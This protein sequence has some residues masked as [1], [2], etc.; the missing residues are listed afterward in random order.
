MGDVSGAARVG[1]RGAAPS[2]AAV[3]LLCHD[4]YFAIGGTRLAH[5][6]L[7]QDFISKSQL[8]EAVAME[9]MALVPLA[10]SWGSTQ[11]EGEVPLLLLLMA[12][13][14]PVLPGLLAGAPVQQVPGAGAGPLQPCCSGC[15]HLC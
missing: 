2:A 9:T 1:S 8:N 14:C 13:S 7:L 5:P 3:V 10:T 11:A 15:C 12:R 4:L 6:V